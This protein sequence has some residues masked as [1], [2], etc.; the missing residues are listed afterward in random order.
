[1]KP[2][3][4]PCPIA[5]ALAGGR[6]SPQ[7]GRYGSSDD[8][9]ILIDMSG[10]EP[11]NFADCSEHLNPTALVDDGTADRA[12]NDGAAA[13]V[14]MQVPCHQAIKREGRATGDPGI[15]IDGTS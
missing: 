13:F 15:S 3:E 5:R 9:C 11:G 4:W 1:M 12:S 2:M 7:L 14:N 8:P 10:A 6:K